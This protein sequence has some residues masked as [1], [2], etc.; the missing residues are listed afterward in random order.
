MHTLNITDSY[1]FHVSV[2]SLAVINTW[3]AQ[4]HAPEFNLHS[5]SPTYTV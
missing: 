3:T 1:M 5:Y 2:D 4:M